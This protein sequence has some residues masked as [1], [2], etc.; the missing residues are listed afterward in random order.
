MWI[1]QGCADAAERNLKRHGVALVIS[2]NAKILRNIS[3]VTQKKTVTEMAIYKTAMP[4]KTPR[5]LRR[6]SP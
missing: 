2:R 6:V 5:F 3:R 4:E 1:S